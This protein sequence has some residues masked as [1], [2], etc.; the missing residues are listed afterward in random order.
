MSI[1]C[2]FRLPQEYL[3]FNQSRIF[4]TRFTLPI[5]SNLVSLFYFNS[6]FSPLSNSPFQS[7]APFT[8]LNL[9]T[10]TYEC[11]Q[12]A[13]DAT[14]TRWTNMTKLIF[15]ST[16]AWTSYPTSLSAM[17]KLTELTI[18]ATT[19]FY[20]GMGGAQF[21]ATITS[22]L[23]NLTFLSVLSYDFGW[24][25]VPD[26]SAS[27]KLQKIVLSSDAFESIPDIF[28]NFKSLV[29][30]DI[31]SN[32]KVSKLPPSLS[33]CTNLTTLIA[34]S[35][36]LSLP[37]SFFDMSN[38][39]L[40][41]MDFD[42]N[43]MTS[44][45]ASLC[46]L[47]RTVPAGTTV[48]LNLENNPIASVASCFGMNTKLTALSLLNTK[49]TSF[50][51]PFL[52]LS[53]L[54]RL[55]WN[56]NEFSMT[57]NVDVSSLSKLTYIDITNIKLVGAFPNT[58]SSLT[59]LSTFAASGNTFKGSMADNFFQRLTQLRYFAVSGSELTGA[60]PSTVGSAGTVTSLI[61]AGNRFTSLP[62]S[63]QNLTN[64]AFIDF[65]D[66][67]LATIPS[68]AIWK[69]MS[70]LQSIAI[71]GNVQ[72]NGPL[73]TFWAQSADFPSLDTVNM[74]YTGFTGNFPSI[75]S[76]KLVNVYITDS[77]L[78]GTISAITRATKLQELRLARNILTGSIPDS[79]STATALTRFEVSNNMLSG[80]LPSNFNLLS[81]LVYF[82]VNDNGLTGALPYVDSLNRLTYF[83]V[84]N[85]QFDLCA[86][87][88]QVSY[89][90]QG[91]CNVT[92]NAFPNACRCPTYY[93]RC[94]AQTT[95]PPP[96]YVPTINPPVD[97]PVP[98][99]PPTAP[100]APAPV[101]APSETS[102]PGQAAAPSWPVPA[103]RLSAIDEPM[104]PTAASSNVA[105]SAVMIVCSAL[106]VAI[107][108]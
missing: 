94:T 95:C 45:P 44:I 20:P 89:R 71:G 38:T 62:N 21:P 108:M 88:P 75:N 31:G 8:V 18:F 24:T 39:K 58:L 32:Y 100:V 40:T 33:Q 23:P 53:G 27:T 97:I 80:S 55:F 78:D 30:L 46:D 57:A 60:F 29:T 2:T 85:N 103:P 56:R 13:I 63:L 42:Y 54:T 69:H 61:A 82:V 36:N 37:D 16:Y 76:T 66:N 79:I 77:S 28:T 3:S 64:L 47:T 72:L 105:V 34:T 17:T 52:S 10:F 86:V 104:V 35:C 1:S 90:V 50:P 98:V 99:K 68:D 4:F 87:N 59:G 14:V 51:T 106:F 9:N 12:C 93:S 96:D 49:M 92:N 6:T 65:S 48:R 19:P 67:Q 26:F 107:F 101:F 83:Q 25:T 5:D 41:S 102:T 11:R 43:K 15:S 74:S 22:D 7:F 70:K 84:Q 91:Y 73:P 81:D